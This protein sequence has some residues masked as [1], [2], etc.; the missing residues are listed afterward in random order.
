VFVLTN[1]MR[2]L[3]ENCVDGITVNHATQETNIERTVGIVTALNPVLGYDE[4]TELAREAYE[5]GKGILE[6]IREKGVL[7]EEQ[8]EEILAPGNLTGLDENQ[9]K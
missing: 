4:A 1:V 5:S 2:T 7:T 9:Y 6:V 3:R 8:I